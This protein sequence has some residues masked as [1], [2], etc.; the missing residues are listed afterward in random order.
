MTKP[1]VLICGDSFAADWSRAR[2]PYPGWPTILGQTLQV[3]NVG[4]AGCSEYK[5]WLQIT[6]QNIR[7]YD[8]VIIAHTS[9][10]RIAIDTHPD[11][12]H[13]PLHSHCDLIY[14]DVAASHNP[15]LACARD[16]FERFYRMDY[17]RFVHELIIRREIEWLQQ[18]GAQSVLHVSGLHGEFMP[19]GTCDMDFS[20]WFARHRGQCNHL[21]QSA[22]QDVA[23]RI[24]AWLER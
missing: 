10:Y 18:H 13:D 14:T 8:H 23:Q 11:H 15:E 19:A 24:L 9:P 20:E 3:T 22:N 5:I 12:H 4:Q 16:F 6:K 2:P 17:A 1:R 7:R 21:N